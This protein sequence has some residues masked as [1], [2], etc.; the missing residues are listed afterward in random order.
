MTPDVAHAWFMSNL[1][2]KAITSF[3]SNLR[4]LILDEAHVYDGVFGTNMAFFLRRLQ[5]VCSAHRLICSTATLGEPVKFVEALTGRHVIEIGAANDGACV[6]EKQ[7][8]L[9]RNA[10]GDAFDATANLVR[11]LAQG[12]SG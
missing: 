2:D 12:F 8:L 11:A 1:H 10:S 4:L 9:A 3:R 7:I 5:A 6:A